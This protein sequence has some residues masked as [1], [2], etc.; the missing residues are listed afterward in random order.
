MRFVRETPSLSGPINLSSPNPTDN[1]GLM[2]ALRR[3]VGAPVGL[4][5]ARFM[6]EPALWALGAESEL[7]L[8]S[9]WVVPDRLLEAGYSFRYPELEPALRDVA[10]R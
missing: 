6:L 1:R 5:A 4:P 8:K 2:A 3:A 7:L 9:R 10:R